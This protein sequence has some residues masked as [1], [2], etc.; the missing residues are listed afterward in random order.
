[1]NIDTK[2]F[3][4][5]FFLSSFSQQHDRPGG[6]APQRRPPG[7][8]EHRTARHRPTAQE[9]VRQRLESHPGS[10]PFDAP[11]D[12]YSSKQRR[13]N[14]NRHGIVPQVRRHGR[15]MFCVCVNTW[16]C[17][18][19]IVPVLQF[20]VASFPYAQTSRDVLG[21][22]YKRYRTHLIE[23]SSV[24]GG[25]G[26][27]WKNVLLQYWNCHIFLVCLV[28]ATIYP[29]VYALKHTFPQCFLT[30]RS[31]MSSLVLN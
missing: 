31:F 26:K 5:L 25:G 6:G 15:N 20:V 19:R 23:F 2:F 28:L 9:L 29:C 8:P 22:V 11:V 14:N 16:T 3:F 1:M 21:N 24:G 30:K 12:A 17:C 18:C 27:F 4:S 10:Q 13:G 7:Q